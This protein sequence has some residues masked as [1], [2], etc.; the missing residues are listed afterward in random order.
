MIY[1]VGY[2]FN[3]VKSSLHLD[4]LFD[5]VILLLIGENFARRKISI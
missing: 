3:D 4:I 2:R 1:K 5:G